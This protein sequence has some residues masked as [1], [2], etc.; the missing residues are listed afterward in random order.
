M[1]ES[2]TRFMKA[3][4]EE[5]RRGWGRTHPNP[6]VGAVMVE[7]GKLVSRGYHVSAGEPHA[8]VQALRN[9]GRKPHGE[10]IL[11]VTL[12]PCC[13]R[14]R[15][16]SCC[17]AIISSGIRRVVVGAID[18]N[19]KHRGRGIEILARAGLRV[20]SGV[21]AEECEDLNIIFNHN[22]IHGRP[23]LAG[24]T[25]TTLDGKVA[26]RCGASQ[27]ITGKIA[28]EDVM[29]WRRLFPGIA[30]GGG[31]VGADDP[32]LTSR[33]PGET[34]CPLRFIFDRNFKTLSGMRN[35]RV[36][37]DTYKARTILVAP[38]GREEVGLY[39]K[40]G[41]QVWEMPG[42]DTFW[43]AFSDTCMEKGV[44]GVFFEGGPGLMSDLLAHGKLDYLFSYRAPK[45]LADEEAPG[46][47]GGWVVE[48]MEE[49]L[50][51]TRVRQAALGRDQLLRGF[52]EYPE[53]SEKKDN[54]SGPMG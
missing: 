34:T 5:A 20:E 9:L 27:W 19:P 17:N 32:N 14:G 54:R 23:L 43:S 30:V 22:Q 28:R 48:K 39:R 45:F 47:V 7:S 11:Y 29:R 10:A 15:T 46:F 3:A 51:L 13:T 31:T 44:T 16:G 1:A 37:N 8:E 42:D 40:Y 50:H 24:K 12:E 33:L 35:Y 52:V 6:M 41:I 36:F 38:A 26:T 18:P 53:T 49:A 25:A 4:L 2:H 21:L